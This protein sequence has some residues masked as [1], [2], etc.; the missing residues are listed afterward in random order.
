MNIGYYADGLW[1]QL[2]L[3][4]ILSDSRFNLKFITPRYD[5]QDPI[6]K[7]IADENSIP[8]LPHQNVNSKEYLDFIKEFKLDIG[9]SMSFNQILKHNLINQPNFGFIN[10]HAGA[11]PFY[12]GRN[13]LNW[14]L[15]NGEKNFG[16]TVH[17]IDEEIDTG[18]IIL[19]KIF[20]IDANDDYKTLLD[21]SSK[22]CA[23]ILYEAL[24]KIYQGTA[25]RVNQNKIHPL[26]FYCSTR[27]KGD[28]I[29]NWNQSSILIHN[30]IRAISDPGP[31]ARTWVNEKEISIQ[32]SELIT[33]SPCYIGKP[34]EVVGKD[35][36]GIIVKTN[37][38]T[39][40][41]TKVTSV[42]NDKILKTEVPSFSIGTRMKDKYK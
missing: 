28:E 10:C 32:K 29:L 8:F 33:D 31:G 22:E 3:K 34:G 15:I 19:Q 23:N 27:I 38:S 37:D 40:K 41:I 13:P 7:K 30:F 2:A 6:L 25:D 16:I 4:K 36:F 12:R 39:I 11:L 26:G 9:I 14:V 5:S 35:K 18:D 21:K 1:G 20:K 24:V 17:H 42:I